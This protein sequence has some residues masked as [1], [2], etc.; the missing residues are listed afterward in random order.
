MNPLRIFVIVKDPAE[1]SIGDLKLLDGLCTDARY[2][3]SGLLVAAES[4]SRV[5]ALFAAFMRA[6]AAAFSRRRGFSAPNFEKRRGS[7]KVETLRGGAAAGADVIID[8]A[9]ARGA[10]E[11]AGVTRF[12]VWRLTSA[13]ADFGFRE[14]ATRAVVTEVELVR[15]SAAHPGG[16]KIAG[17]AFNTKFIAAHNAAFAREKAIALV[18][19]E[20]ARL[21]LD[22]DVRAGVPPRPRGAA[23]STADM[24]VYGVRA[25]GSLAMRLARAAAARLRLRPGMF[26]LMTAAGSPFDF[27]PRKG[28]RIVPEGDHYWADPF[29][30]RLRN[31]TYVFFEDYDYRTKRG[32][33]SVA[34][35]EDG[36]FNVIGAALKTDY[37]LSYPLVFAEG[38]DVFMIPETS[39]TRRIEVWRATSFP[40]G[41]ELH[42]TALQ[43]EDCA[44]SAIAQH[45]GEWWLFTNISKDSYRD[46]C[47]ELHVFRVDGPSLGNPAPHP[48]N[49]VVIDSRT[50]RGAGR[51]FAM[52]GQLFRMSQV[53]EGGEYGYGVNIMKIKRLDMRD[54]QEEIVRRIEPTFDSALIGCHH[55]DFDGDLVIMDIRKKWGGFAT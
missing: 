53:N 12:G 1:L 25:A 24:A 20:L 49:P 32:E 26:M 51:V 19:R 27:D 15:F 54:Y 41:W 29:I 23:P 30:F 6:E 2:E 4:E 38:E 9:D 35:I 33:I 31:K 8:I 22:G 36:K 7:I 37:H 10:P 34:E 17:A 18:E 44:D 13:A 52:D 47:S 14:A 55:L 21:C 50:A 5:S 45:R 46:H 28:T 3:L 40:T 11:L 16:E 42:A 48:L 43:G 39:Q